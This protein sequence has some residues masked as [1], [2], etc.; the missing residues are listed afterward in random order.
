MTRHGAG[1]FDTECDVNE[2]G[3]NIVDLTNRTNPHQGM[4]RYGR[5]ELAG[6]KERIFADYR[7]S[8][9][10]SVSLAV[11]HND[12]TNNEFVLNK[13]EDLAEFYSGFD[14]IYMSNGASRNSVN[15]YKDYMNAEG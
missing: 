11:T 6:L 8:E 3:E 4:L 12:E 14:K 7:K 10:T 1:T 9:K 5:M 13:D 2:I 15:I